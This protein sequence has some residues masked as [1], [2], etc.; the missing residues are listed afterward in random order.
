[1]LLHAFIPASRANGPGL[2]AVVFF[3]GCTLACR[4]C[5]N[6]E[7]HSFVGTEVTVDA[8]ADK[9]LRAHKEHGVEGVT[10]TGGEPM[11]QAP[12]L[13]E[14]TQTLRLRVPSLSFGL[15]SGYSDLEL[16]LGRYSIWGRDRSEPDRRRLW[17]E[18]R[19]HLDFAVLGR[20]NQAQP[21]GL[22]LRT[23]RSKALRMLSSR[24]SVK[25][26]GPQSVEVI[27]HSDGRAEVTGFP[28]LGVPWQEPPS[29]IRSPSK[30]IL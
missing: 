28:I 7:T 27:I 29:S 2:R 13:L 12:A 16:V 15:F 10:F 23:S 6:P 20:F 18:I 9:V 4:G 14:L 24:Y 30:V 1:M 22:P 17:E 11:Q 19:E 21:S 5:F 25:D 26:Y 8:V 3:Q